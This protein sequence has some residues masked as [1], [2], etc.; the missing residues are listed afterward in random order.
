MDA[1]LLFHVRS[2]IMLVAIALALATYLVMPRPRPLAFRVIGLITALALLIETSNYLM[3]LRQLNNTW[4]YN[5]FTTVEFLL[6]LFMA[7]RLRPGWRNWLV[8]GAL[9]GVGAMVLNAT[10]VSP[11]SAMLIEGIVTLSFIAALT[12]GALLWSLAMR[13]TVALHRAPEFWLF[14]GLLVYFSALP[15]V[16][17]LAWTFREKD[18]LL[19]TTLWTIMPVLCILRYLLAAYANRLQGRTRSAHG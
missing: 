12:I 5:S 8:V 10:S 13:S 17:L 19:V 11:L 3:S 16:V 1:I 2:V 6:L 9:V 7:W 4:V 14:M 18:P 15:P